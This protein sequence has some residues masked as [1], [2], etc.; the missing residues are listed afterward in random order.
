MPRY[1]HD[2]Q[3]IFA[4][5]NDSPN[6]VTNEELWDALN[7]RIGDLRSNPEGLEGDVWPPIETIDNGEEQ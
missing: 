2:F 7:E 3:L 6:N 4:V 1:T 5:N